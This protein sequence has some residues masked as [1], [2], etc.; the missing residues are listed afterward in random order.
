[1]FRGDSRSQNGTPFI[2]KCR[3]CGNCTLGMVFL[4]KNNV[5]RCL[6]LKYARV[7]LFAELRRCCW[8]LE[9]RRCAVQGDTVCTR[10]RA[11]G[12][13]QDPPKR[14][15]CQNRNAVNGEFLI[16][17][18]HF[19]HNTMAHAAVPCNTHT[20]CRYVYIYQY[21]Y[22]YVYY[23]LYMYI[24]IY[25]Y[26]ISVTLIRVWHPGYF[27]RISITTPIASALKNYYTGI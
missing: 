5:T 4:C 16:I 26:N 13:F 25:I 27:T 10:Y 15:T 21:I 8:L 1:M 20:V 22:I 12:V 23:I 11:L 24:Y 17:Q 6:N 19:C 14:T 3:G 9:Q 18:L 7:T 2:F